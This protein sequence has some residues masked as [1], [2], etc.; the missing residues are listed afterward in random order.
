MSFTENNYEQA[1]IQLFQ[2]LGYKHLYAPY[3]ER[4]YYV[5]FYQEQLFQS[6]YEKKKKKQEEAF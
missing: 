2:Q 5:P 4:D 6:L 3:I 1:L